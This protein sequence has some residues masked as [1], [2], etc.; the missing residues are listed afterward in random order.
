MTIPTNGEGGGSKQIDD[1]KSPVPC[2]TV[3]LLGSKARLKSH[4][5][6]DLGPCI[7]GELTFNKSNQAHQ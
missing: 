6:V 3:L 5:K 2:H 7:Y 1:Q 4:W